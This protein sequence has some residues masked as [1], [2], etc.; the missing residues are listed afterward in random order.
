[1]PSRSVSS[2]SSPRSWATNSTKKRAGSSHHIVL[3][4]T[5]YPDL[6]LFPSIGVS[7]SLKPP[8]LSAMRPLIS[9]ASAPLKESAAVR[10]ARM[11]SP[12]PLNAC[13]SPSQWTNRPLPLRTLPSPSPTLD[14]PRSSRKLP[15]DVAVRPPVSMSLATN[16]LMLTPMLPLDPG[17]ASVQ[18]MTS[19][20]FGSLPCFLTILV[21][22]PSSPCS[23]PFPVL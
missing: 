9:F 3:L 5:L 2:K 14:L 1:M 21:P 16:P 6:P 17:S 23:L 11:R 13:N 4:A 12:G 10:L 18:L 7:R 15:R 8:T 20:R 19:P 22:L